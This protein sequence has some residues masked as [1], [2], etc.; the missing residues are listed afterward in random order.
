[1]L[2]RLRKMDR[3]LLFCILGMSLLGAASGISE[4]SFNNFL[5]DTYDL[6]ADA[7]G[8]LEFPRELPGFLT[9][10]LA[11]MLFF[12]PETGIAAV[13][14]LTVGVGLAGL[15]FWGASWWPMLGFMTLWSVGVH[16]I[17]PVR[18]SLGMELGKTGEKGKRLGQLQ[19][20]GIAASIGG[21]VVVWV[22]T[23]LMPG[24]Y[25]PLFLVGTAVA[26]LGAI[27][28]MFM[29]MPNAHLTR[30]RFVWRKRYWLYYVLNLFFG[31]RKQIFI[32]FGPWVLVKIFNQPAYIF[33]QLWIVAAVLGVIFQP[34]LGR[35]IDRYGERMVLMADA[36]VTFLICLGYGWAHLL[37]N[38]QLAL[39]LLYT[40]F[41]IDQ[42]IFG[43]GMAR[44]LYVARIAE[45]PDHVAPTL[46]MG[47]SINH[48]VS[49]SIPSL[50]G[51]A[52]EYYGHSSVFM[53][54][55][56]V[57]VFVFIFSSLIEP[58]PTPP[59]DSAG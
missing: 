18:S 35:A 7:R 42:L 52:W 44:D 55:A 31:A 58:R 38:P 37:P 47:V 57:A 10:L 23:R 1:M 8:Y 33:A 59:A 6:S 17:M 34:L 4:T 32:T 30:R 14:A 19:A 11:G 40:C 51:L 50:G 28:F 53:G 46:S 39:W 25:R 9:A 13:C 22:M 49:M 29:R 5:H 48:I 56:G 54:A 12:L 24:N 27:S 15:A 26:V 3:N 21:C 36:V 43:T 45:Q 16:L 2:D 20:S 41:V